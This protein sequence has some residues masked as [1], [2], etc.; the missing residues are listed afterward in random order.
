MSALASV[1]WA[2]IN[3]VPHASEA[4]LNKD[5]PDVNR[6]PSCESCGSSLAALR[7][8]L[9]ESG[10]IHN[11]T[12][13]DI[14]CH[15]E[16]RG[17]STRIENAKNTRTGCDPIWAIPFTAANRV[18]MPLERSSATIGTLVSIHWNT[19]EQPMG[20]SSATNLGLE[21]ICINQF[22]SANRFHM[23]KPHSYAIGTLVSKQ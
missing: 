10:S 20:H 23:H 5:F 1:C 4:G 2:S 9:G 7:I 11:F 17:G 15:T 14:G 19:R 6:I 12:D 21:S 16:A 13:F 8:A 3:R 18:R 22:T